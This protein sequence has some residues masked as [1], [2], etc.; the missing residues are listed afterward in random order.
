MLASHCRH[1]SPGSSALNC[2][3]LLKFARKSN[4]NFHKKKFTPIAPALII[5]I[6]SHLFNLGCIYSSSFRLNMSL[7]MCFL[8]FIDIHTNTDAKNE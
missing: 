1:Q 8:V 5:L 4:D 3:H 6:M 7:S 2:V